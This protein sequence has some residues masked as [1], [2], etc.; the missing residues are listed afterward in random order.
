MIGY[1]FIYIKGNKIDIISKTLGFAVG[2]MI[3]IS[4]I[5]LIP[6]SL[7]LIICNYSFIKSLIII[8]ISFVT[9]IIVSN[10]FDNKMNNNTL[11]NSK[12][13]KI[14]LITMITLIIHN[15]PEGIATY[16]TSIN[17]LKLG[18]VFTIAI[19]LHNIPEGIA[20]SIP[21][22]YSTNKKTKAFLYTFVAGLSEFLGALISYVLLSKIINNI[23]LGI[24]YS[25]IAGLMINISINKLCKESFNYN[26]INTIKYFIIG[27]VIMILTHIYIN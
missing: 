14:G 27:I 12:L 20:I 5:D 24:I 4:I 7:R 11:N 6:N 3:T 25:F 23:F 26:K 21:I 19:A 18:I 1:L 9:G 17:N 22:Y 8:I 15:I 16:I 2:I 13:Y 10:L